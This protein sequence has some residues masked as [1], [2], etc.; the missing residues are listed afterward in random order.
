M[1]I[2]LDASALLRFLDDEPGAERV[3]Q[4]LSRA[5]RGEVKL[6]MSAVN[7]GELIYAV[8]RKTGADAARALAA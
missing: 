4:L 7:W 6:L 1:T 8:A 2:I 5:R 3:Q